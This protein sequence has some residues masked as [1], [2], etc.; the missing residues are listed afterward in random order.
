MPPRNTLRQPF[1]LF[2]SKGELESSLTTILNSI[3]R[4]SVAGADD[5]QMSMLVQA[6]QNTWSRAAR[7]RKLAGTIESSGTNPVDLALCCRIR[8]AE[9]ETND[10]CKSNNENLVL[11]FEWVAG[12]DRGLF[13]SFMS[14]VSRKLNSVA[15]A[16]DVEMAG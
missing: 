14:H 9:A 12:R 16:S 11:E 13:E 2:H 4:A 8:C 15:K 5:T 10:R 7:R 6:A 3:H 1:N